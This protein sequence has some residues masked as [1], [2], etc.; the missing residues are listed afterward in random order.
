MATHNSFRGYGQVM[1]APRVIKTDDG[2]YSRASCAIMT[3]RGKR[4]IGDS[5]ENIRYDSPALRTSNPPLCDEISNW[6]VG[7]MVEVK[8]TITS[9]EITR[10]NTCPECG[11]EN[12]V[13]GVMS[14]IHPIFCTRIE[15]NI[16]PEEGLRLLKYRN[17]ISNNVTIIGMLTQEPQYHKT[18][19]GS[20]IAKYQIAV[21]RRY[22]I[23]EDEPTRRAD[24]I[25]IKSFGK[26]AEV[27][28]KYLKKGT[29]IYIDGVLQTVNYERKIVCAECGAEF[30]ASETSLEVV[31]YTVEYLRDYL[32]QEDGG[33]GTQDKD[34]LEYL[35]GESKVAQKAHDVLDSLSD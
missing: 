34:S 20:L 21:M 32:P 30:S 22:R 8:G 24:F 5:L 7:D 10:T 15:S 28:Q 18:Q 4:S 12:K 35:V 19:S 33:D 31:P 25:W 13:Q 26:I 16:P 11:A 23:K 6:K 2:E 1:L 27:D 14:Y 9:R 29:L 17:E 3:I